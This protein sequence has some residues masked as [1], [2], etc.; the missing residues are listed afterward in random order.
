MRPAIASNSSG[1]TQTS[2]STVFP[3]S[4]E[5]GSGTACNLGPMATGADENFWRKARLRGVL[6]HCIIRRY[7][8]IFLSRTSTYSKEA[9]YFDGYAGRGKYEDGSLGSSGLM[10]QFAINQKFSQGRDYTLLLYELDKESFDSLAQLAEQYRQRGLDVRADRKNVVA[11]LD[12]VV[13]AAANKPLF[14][15]LDP[16]GVGV[17]FDAMVRLL[18]R[19]APRHQ[20]PTEVL[21]NFNHA[22]VRRIGGHLRSPSGNEATI[23]RMDDAVGGTW[24]H[25]AFEQTEKD[26]VRFVVDGFKERLA[27]ATGMV[28]QSVVVSDGPDKPPIY[29]LVFG[30]RNPHGL[31]NFA[32]AAALCIKDWWEQSEAAESQGALF[33][34]Q[35]RVEDV[36]AEAISI[37]EGNIERLLRDRGEFV[38][39]NYPEEVFGEYIGRVRTMVARAAVKRLYKRGATSSDGKSPNRQKLEDMVVRPAP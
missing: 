16:C 1:V 35:P 4:G 29:D 3:D 15:F 33:L 39:G 2:V 38:L 18:N 20:P 7:L 11:V 27:G 31:W 10:M 19:N 24:W 9:V 17:P 6:K 30:T 32:D 25:E 26:V 14:V 34:V 13:A 36:E 21:L 8:P 28:V 12:E 22:A 5:V 37:V 23:R